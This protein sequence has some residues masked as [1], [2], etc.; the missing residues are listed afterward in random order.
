MSIL[1]AAPSAPARRPPRTSPPPVRRR[2]QPPRM[3]EAEFLA[4]TRDPARVSD[5]PGAAYAPKYELLEGGVV[6]EMANVRHTHAILT[7]EL[8]FQIRL[9]LDRER[10]VAYTESIKFR[11][12]ACQIYCP[13]NVVAPNPPELL[14]SYG[15]VVLD[16]VFLAEVLSDSTADTDRGEKL[17]CYLGTPSVLEYWLVHQDRVRVERY[18]REPGGSWPDEP[19]VHEDRSAAVPL[20]ALG[21]A[22]PVGELYRQAV[23][24]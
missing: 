20:P 19:E 3:T 15:D 9:L 12:R 10:F 21:G 5:R 24:G 11:P 16:P 23:P 17:D 22:V 8:H 13:D 7:G 2:D 18:H 4:F 6:R 1:P 14:D